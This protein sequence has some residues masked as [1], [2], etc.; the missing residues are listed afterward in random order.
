MSAADLAG[1]SAATMTVAAT[2]P[3][4]LV[5]APPS[6]RLILGF[7]ARDLAL[8]AAFLSFTL[9]AIW[10]TTS[11]VE[12]RQRRIVSVSLSTIIKDFVAAQAR[13]AA[14]PEIAAARTRAYL[15]AT[16]AAMQ[17]L[18]RDGT[19]VL[20][21]EAVVGNSVPDMTR[22]VSAAVNAWL[23]KA[24]LELP[25]PSV[26]AAPPLAAGTITGNGEAVSPLGASPFGPPTRSP[27]SPLPEAGDGL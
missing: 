2:E 23:A 20:V 18:S 27:P 14:S 7:A 10:A 19:T 21:S 13:T 5:G 3:A 9:W 12:L 6:P 8:V 24:P 15:A 11:L 22:A 17:S 1:D 4:P 25:A 16:D 26:S